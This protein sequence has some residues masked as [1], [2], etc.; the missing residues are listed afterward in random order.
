ML[1][2]QLQPLQHCPVLMSLHTG[3][4]NQQTASI[5]SQ[6]ELAPIMLSHNHNSLFSIPTDGSMP[7]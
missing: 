4:P 7:T 2:E 3:I 6:T 1:E 5:V